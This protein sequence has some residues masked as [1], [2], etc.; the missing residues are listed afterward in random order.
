MI[1][2]SFIVRVLQFL[3]AVIII[4]G[5][6]ALVW[7]V[8]LYSFKLTID[9]LENSNRDFFLWLKTKFPFRQIIEKRNKKLTE[10]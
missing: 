9:A 3:L 1:A 6:L 2:V 10:H 8:L 7:F 5:G 4:G